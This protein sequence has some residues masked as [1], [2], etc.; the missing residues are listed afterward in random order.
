MGN[1]QIPG[2]D[3]SETYAPVMRLESLRTLF[4]LAAGLDWEIHQCDVTGA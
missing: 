2:F 1:H 4:S 3:Y